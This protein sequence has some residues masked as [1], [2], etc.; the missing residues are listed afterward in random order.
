VGAKHEIYTIIN[1][2]AKRGISIV[3]VSSELSEILGLC[4]RVLVMHEGKI[5]GEFPRDEA[6]EEKIMHAATL[7]A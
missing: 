4:D 5:S 2:L 6:T 3:M 1:D 7:G